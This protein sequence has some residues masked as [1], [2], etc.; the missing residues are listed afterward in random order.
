MADFLTI[1]DVIYQL[2]MFFGNTALLFLKTAFTQPFLP[3]TIIGLAIAI[4]GAMV[5]KS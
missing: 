1:L 3:F 4:L 2:M 5:A